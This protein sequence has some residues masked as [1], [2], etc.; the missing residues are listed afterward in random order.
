MAKATPNRRSSARREGD[1]GN[2]NGGAA[3]IAFRDSR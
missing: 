2:R 1:H 3:Q